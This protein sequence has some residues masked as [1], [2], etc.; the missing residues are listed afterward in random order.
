MNQFPTL[1]RLRPLLRIEVGIL[2]VVLVIALIWYNQNQQV[3]DARDE[4]SL[5]VQKINAANDDLAVFEQ[6]NARAALE[7]EL[8]QL[9]SEQKPVV[10]P[11]RRDALRLNDELLAYADDQQL[12]LPAY[13]RKEMTVTSA[14]Q[15]F[16]AVRYSI[17]AQGSAAPL[18]GMLELL[19][20]F[21][22][23]KVQLLQFVR[24]PEGQDIWEMSLELDVF[25]GDEGT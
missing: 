12:G 9:Q 21:P 19:R 16:P 15:E 10:L 11:T 5:M 3:G 20:D 24:P 8:A 2:V 18:V 14:E 1:Q 4:E 17:V 23:A 7:E 22:S 13:H 6:T 25:Y